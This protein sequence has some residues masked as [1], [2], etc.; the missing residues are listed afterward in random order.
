[1]KKGRFLYLTIFILISLFASAVTARRITN[2]IRPSVK[3]PPR[4]PKAMRALTRALVVQPASVT[5]NVLGVARSTVN[6]SVTATD[7]YGRP[8][9]YSITTL[10]AHGTA[11]IVPDTGAFTY[12]IAGHT[13][14]AS[15]L[16]MVTVSNGSAQSTAQVDVQLASDPLLPNQW[17][18]QNVGQ[19]AFASVLPIAG[20]DMNVAGAW[21]AGY[22]G[23]GIKIGVVDTGLEAAHEDLAANV[24]VGN[25][26]NFI[27]ELNDPSRDPDDP[28][29]DH[30]TAVAGIIGAVAFNGKG[31]RG[32]AYDAR[33]RGYNLLNYFSAANMAKS[34]GSDPISSDNDLFNASF[35]ETD[36]ALPSFSG[37]Y[38]DITST[39]LTLRNGLGAA[40]VNAAGNDFEDWNYYPGRYCGAANKFKVS[41]GDPANDER[42]GGYAPIIVGAIDADGKHSGYSNTGSSLWISAPAGEYGL[43]SDYTS[44]I[45]YAPAIITTSRTGC[46][47]SPYYPDSVNALDSMGA[48]PLAP[49]CEYTAIMNGTS[50]ATPNVAGVVAMM[51]EANP[52]LSVR[53]IKYILAKTARKTDPTFSG[54]S[55]TEVILGSTVVLEQGWVTN[56]A[57]WSFSNRYGFGAVNASAAVEM[58]E[59]Y[60]SYLP[61]VRDDTPWYEFLAPWPAIVT[62]MSTTGNSGVFEVAEPF[63]TVEFVVVFLNIASTPGSLVC[64]QVELKSPSGTK[65]ILMHAGNG[66]QNASVV[67]SRF[68]T[69]AFYGEPVNGDWVLTFYHWCSTDYDYTRLSTT[70]PQRLAIIGH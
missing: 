23:K 66:F 58:A 46:A 67:D 15:D 3:P 35:G 33:L 52:S 4:Q 42:R 69:N 1:M 9:T 22:S 59:S 51:L 6:G 43:N 61:P 38:Q 21:T 70:R 20:N 48:N 18:I 13:S 17:H 36:P 63:N 56:S 65:S 24:D 26:F 32:V 28:G 16:F 37:A 5:V 57:G 11:S 34:M 49:N 30:G 10:P 44:D 25:S 2:T 27:T 50:A 39:T 54:V 31:G 60:T 62:P 68:V 29:F 19:D 55:S 8:L 40:I 45:N 14:A 53:D 64:N 47:N 41:C 12:S 7:L